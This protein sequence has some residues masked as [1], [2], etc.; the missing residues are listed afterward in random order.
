MFLKSFKTYLNHELPKYIKIP[1]NHKY[2]LAYNVLKT[3]RLLLQTLI[4]FIFQYLTLMNLTFSLPPL[5]MNPAIGLAFSF[6]YLIGKNA[7]PGLILGELCAL[8]LKGMSAGSILLYLSAD[9]GL[10]SIAAFYCNAILSS[11]IRTFA[12]QRESL[13]F[14]K[15]NALICLLTGFLRVWADF[16]NLHTLQ[17]LHNLQN[18]HHVQNLQ[19]PH[20]IQ[21]HAIQADAIQAGSNISFI[22]FFNAIPNTL[23]NYFD[24]FIADLN[25]ILVL[26]VFLISWVSIP[27]T[28][29]KIF[30]G[31]LTQYPATLMAM[32]I[33]S[34]LLF[35]NRSS[36]HIVI[37]AILVSLYVLF[38]YG[39]KKGLLFEDKLKKS[40]LIALFIFILISLL[41]MK[42]VELIY[43]TV[44]LMFAALYLSYVY[45]YLIASALL[46][47]LSSIYMAC[48]ANLN[49]IFVQQFGLVTYTVIPVFLFIYI[50]AMI[51]LGH[52]KIRTV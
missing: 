19:I 24:H 33:I 11:D 12:S 44:I 27:F 26:S 25:G 46:F 18:L 35:M 16:L 15:T 2:W 42:N 30:R 48:F 1:S 47:I 36:L 9:I 32:V 23:I 38:I 13:H 17:N 41:F 6:F 21:A 14:L 49:E 8:A 31:S 22:S 45:G 10:G 34:A 43:F 5:P 39:R 29:E 51:G 40:P 7:F 28:R 3:K 52:Y 4:V 20:I 37:F 50:V